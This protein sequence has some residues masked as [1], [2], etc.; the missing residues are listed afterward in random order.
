M[1]RWVVLAAG[2]AAWVGFSRAAEPRPNVIVIMADDQGTVDA[3]C[4]G[5]T[6][7]ET[8]AIDRLAREGIRFTQFYSAAPVCSPSRAGLL[9]GRYPPR[10]GVPNNAPSESGKAGMPPSEV[11][12][13]E[14]FKAAGYA[15]AHVG[16]WHLG[17]SPETM[18]NAQGFDLSF[19]HMGG[20]IDNYS[21]FFYW[22]GPNRHDLHLD[23]VEIHRPGRFF[24]DM[25]VE[26]AS[27]FLRANRAGPFFV[28]FA[29]NLPHYPYQGDEKWLKRYASLPHPRNLYAAFV[30]TLDERV[31]RLLDELDALGLASN[32]V[33]VYQSDNGHSTEERA[34]FGGGS[35]GEYRGAK[36]S[37]FEGGI[38]VPALVRWPGRIP[39]GETRGQ[40]AHGC[41]WMPTL[42]ELCGVTPPDAR[43][44][45]RSLVPVI[46]KAA[47]PSAHDVLH[48]QVGGPWAVREG[49]WKLLGQPQ[50]TGVRPAEKLPRL[51]LVNL[52]DDP[53]ER[54]NL[55]DR[56]PDRVTRLKALHDAWAADIGRQQP[57]SNSQLPTTK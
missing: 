14:M 31:G 55:A 43:L 23:G 51:F 22:Q 39:A 49:D 54:T 6:D 52:R 26:E 46:R 25:M 53:R 11:T 38:R 32:T 15:T 37:L 44:D 27:A 17:Y 20:C 56:E 13:A 19:G 42:A 5:S 18:P 16:K 40:M 50:D 57:T 12:M 4:C 47:A 30:S 41:D 3:R 10:A 35:A 21:H 7:I 34:H 29:L 45:G 28:Y 48:W 36:F 2:L 9:T 24:P 1:R 8:P 33:V